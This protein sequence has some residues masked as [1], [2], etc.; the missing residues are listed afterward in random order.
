MSPSRLSACLAAATLALCACAQQPSK[1]SPSSASAASGSA[2]K[3]HAQIDYS[4]YVK[5]AVGSFWFSSLHDWDSNDP[6]H[7]VVWVSPLEA[8]RLNLLGPC[9]G[10]QS[11]MTLLLTSH[12]G[13]VSAGFDSIIVQGDRPLSYNRSPTFRRRPT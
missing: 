5:H 1:P 12:G 11:S 8:Y 10:L 13:Q 9:F 2:R 7:V 4:K 3:S 6:S